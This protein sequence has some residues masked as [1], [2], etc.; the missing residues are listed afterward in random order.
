MNT[1]GR[2]V[3]KTDERKQAVKA[4]CIGHCI[5]NC[6]VSPLHLTPVFLHTGLLMPG[7]ICHSQWTAIAVEIS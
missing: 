2:A 6:T 7:K 4:L 5:S 1:S 3:T